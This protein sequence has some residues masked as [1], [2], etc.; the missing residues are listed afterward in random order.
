MSAINSDCL[1]LDVA[2]D[3]ETMKPADVLDLYGN[4]HCCLN[5]LQ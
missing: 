3:V 1:V 4:S 5:S 2:H